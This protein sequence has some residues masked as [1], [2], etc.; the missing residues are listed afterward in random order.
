MTSAL[1]PLLQAFSG[2]LGSAA[3]NTLTYPLDLVATRVQIQKPSRKRSSGFANGSRILQH[4]VSRYG[5][6]ALYDGISTD[7][8][9]T[10]LSKWVGHRCQGINLDCPL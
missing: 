4:I 1:P 5:L 7:T 8:F 6:S 2:A 9:A 10:L 3:A